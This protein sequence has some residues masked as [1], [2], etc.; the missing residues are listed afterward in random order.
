MHFS[1]YT[2]DKQN[3]TL[4]TVENEINCFSI[5]IYSFLDY[6]NVAK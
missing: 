1:Y 3:K 4:V 2:L 6:F 5:T